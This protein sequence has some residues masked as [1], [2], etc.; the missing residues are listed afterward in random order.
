MSETKKDTIQDAIPEAEVKKPYTFRKLE[1]PDIFVMF[2]IIS[3][4]GVNEFKACLEAEGFK[5]LVSKMTGTDVNKEE[6]SDD[7][8]LA[9]GASVVLE[10]AQVILTNLPKCEKEIYQILSQTS[11]LKLEQVKKLDAITFFEMVIDFIKKEEFKDFFKVV[12]KLF[13]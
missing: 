1:A 3:A 7:D 9:L 13:K 8:F 11:N 4:I 2:K 10:L 12:S 6:I 5:D